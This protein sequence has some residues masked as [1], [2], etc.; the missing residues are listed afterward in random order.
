MLKSVYRLWFTDLCVTAVMAAAWHGGPPGAGNF[1]NDSTL[2]GSVS[3][4][5]DFWF[6]ND[7]TNPAC[8]DQGGLVLRHFREEAVPGLQGQHQEQ[9]L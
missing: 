4:A 6:D 5:M 2:L 1:V 9:L 8:L 7:F 3:S